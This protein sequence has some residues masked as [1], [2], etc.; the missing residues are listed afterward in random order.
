MSDLTA[1]NESG[2]A[3]RFDS[4]TV[5][6][7]ALKGR[8]LPAGWRLATPVEAHLYRQLRALEDRVT[9]IE[10]RAKATEETDAQ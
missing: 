3:T 9:A 10:K 8:C 2:V 6:S 1:F 7:L 4:F 5:H